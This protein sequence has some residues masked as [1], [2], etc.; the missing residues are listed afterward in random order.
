MIATYR[1]ELGK[2]LRRRLVLLTAAIAVLAAAAG[3]AIVVTAATSG[4]PGGGP[5]RGPTVE[6]L[7]TAGGGTEVFRVA[8]AFAGTFVFVLF[9]GLM[10]TEISRGT[11]RTMLL[12]QPRR[13]RLLAGRLAAQLTFAA[14]ALLLAEVVAWITARQLAPG[15]GIAVASWS[16]ASA[17]A[18]AATDYGAVV[19]WVAG[20]A[21]FGTTVALLL[22]SVPLALAVG[23]AWAGPVE[24]LLQDAWEPATRWFPGLLLEAFVAGGTADVGSGRALATVAGYVLLAAVLGSLVF[25]RRD[26]T[27]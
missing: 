14:G 5:G 20:Y 11:I 3:A 4:A 27:A 12:R 10:A 25:T 6:E 15:Q 22:R 26:V 8:A 1:S 17:H 24:H 19:L 21:V 2:L 16:T 18:Q 13:A 7:S 9:V 23:V